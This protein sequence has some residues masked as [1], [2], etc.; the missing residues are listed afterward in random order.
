[1]A[2]SYLNDSSLPRG[3]RNNNPFNLIMTSISWNG[4]IPT[5]LN[6]DGHF[7][8]FE[9]VIMGL[10]AGLMDVLNDYHKKGKTTVTELISE[11][12][13]SFE[14]NTSGYI[15]QI[16]DAIGGDNIEVMGRDTIITMALAIVRVEN[17][18]NYVDKLSYSDYVEALNL[19]GYD[20]P[21]IGTVSKKK[22]VTETTCRCCGK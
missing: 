18:S 2:K 22:V 16:Q 17:G 15:K 11:F 5:V 3:L 12:A 13:P 6:T 20:L 10:R 1:M 8:Q 14:N 4:K 9:N 7:E 21:E 19:T